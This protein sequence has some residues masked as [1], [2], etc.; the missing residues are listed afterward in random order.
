MADDLLYL[1][2]LTVSRDKQLAQQ[3]GDI[4]LQ[5]IS[6]HGSFQRPNSATGAQ[7]SSSTSTTTTSSPQPKYLV[8]CPDCYRKALDLVR[9]RYHQSRAAGAGEWC[10]TRRSFLREIDTMLAGAKEYQVDPRTIDDRMQ[11]EWDS[12]YLEVVQSSILRLL[13]TVIGKLDEAVAPEDADPAAAAAK[14]AIVERI[15]ELQQAKQG[16]RSHRNVLR[17]TKD[18][19]KLLKGGKEEDGDTVMGGMETGFPPELAAADT[20][21]E[22]RVKI[23]RRAFA[24]TVAEGGDEKNLQ[25]SQKKYCDMFKDGTTPLGQVIDRILD[26]KK[27]AW[28]AQAKI[29]QVKKRLEDLKRAR[30]AYELQ[31]TKKA[32]ISEHK[33]PEELYNLPPC[34]NCGQMP[35]TRDFLTCPICMVLVQKGV[36][37]RQTVWCSSD[38]NTEGLPN[39]IETDHECASKDDCV[40][41][42]PLR[43]SHQHYDPDQDVNMDGTSTVASSPV[44]SD[45]N[46]SSPVCFCRECLTTLKC[47]SV[48]CSLRCYDLNFQGHR[49]NIHMPTRRRLNKIVTDRQH[50]EYFPM[51]PLSSSSGPSSRDRDRGDRDYRNRGNNNSN[52]KDSNNNDDGNGPNSGFGENP[53]LLQ[54]R[55]RYKARNIKDHV[56]PFDEAISNWEEANQVKA[57]I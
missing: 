54:T 33:V 44:D 12:W 7:P 43:H 11:A 23:M 19:D 57:Q 1:S 3:L 55:T 35:N 52:N 14:D 51:P 47:E 24:S 41:V 5:C 40:Q 29:G 32:S 4:R 18:I 22:D 27:E 34:H 42:N 16:A 9:A 39:H 6:H 8:T 49:E 53:P 30:A 28:G 38:C 45:P 10:T 36:R 17:L 37:E 31:K 56:I 15:E 48:F 13:P 50:L 20:S 46:A 26:D 25:G 2:S 21:D